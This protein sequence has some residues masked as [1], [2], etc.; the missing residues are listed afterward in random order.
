MII[1]SLMWDDFN[2]AHIARHAVSREE[3]EQVCMGEVFSTEAYAGRLRVIGSTN[4]GRMLTVIMASKDETTYYV[5]T[6]RS[7][8]RPERKRYLQFKEKDAA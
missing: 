4:K 7:A 8:S 6:A 1:T 2:E 5:V 3:V